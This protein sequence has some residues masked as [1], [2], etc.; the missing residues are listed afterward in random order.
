MLSTFIKPLLEMIPGEYLGG[1]C[2]IGILVGI[3]FKPIQEN[4]L[5][6]EKLFLCDIKV[7]INK[8]NDKIERAIF[9]YYIF[10]IIGIFIAALILVV[11]YAVLLIYHIKFIENLNKEIIWIGIIIIYIILSEVLVNILYIYVKMEKKIKNM[12]RGVGILFAVNY[13]GILINL[14]MFQWVTGIGIIGLLIYMLFY[15]GVKIKYPSK[16]KIFLKNNQVL[17]ARY[18]N[19]K[20]NSHV[21]KIKERIGNNVAVKIKVYKMSDVER[22]EYYY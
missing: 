15:N 1:I 21:L 11:I 10:A 9:I 4:I 20:I 18:K 5:D 22:W 6:G 8:K 14:Q 19:V 13:I 7:I 12:F 16:M 2:I 3:F 17:D